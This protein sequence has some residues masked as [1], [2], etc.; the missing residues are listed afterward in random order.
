MTTI[1]VLSMAI[2]GGIALVVLLV[3]TWRKLN[4]GAL[5]AICLAA[6][7]AVP[8]PSSA[9]DWPEL[10]IDALLVAPGDNKEALVEATWP[11]RPENRATLVVHFNSTKQSDLQILRG[12]QLQGASIVPMP[13]SSTGIELRRRGT[14]TH[15]DATVLSETYRRSP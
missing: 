5:D 8:N 1:L 15:V 7:T 14:R 13:S 6:K 2:T 10:R 4:V 12:W 9:C 3:H 11:G